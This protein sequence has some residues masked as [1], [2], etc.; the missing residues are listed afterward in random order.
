VD[1][2][3][4]RLS[5]RSYVLGQD[6]PDDAVLQIEIKLLIEVLDGIAEISGAKGTVISNTEYF[7]QLRTSPIVRFAHWPKIARQSR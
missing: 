3:F 1:W 5:G 6:V 7:S 2:D 4:G